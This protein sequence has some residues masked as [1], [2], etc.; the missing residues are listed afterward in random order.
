MIAYVDE[1]GM[2]T[3]TPP[4]PSK[5]KEV[6]LKDIQISM[7]KREESE[8]MDPNRNGFVT[9]YNESKGFG[10]IQDSE[11][12]EKVFVHINNCNDQIIEGNKVSF[13]IENGQK[14]PVA[15]K[16]NLLK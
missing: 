8:E 3:S 6:K 13:E 2:I 7:P 10:F 16:V 4:D 5:K 15:I 14:G 1:K 11:T 12:K 9:F